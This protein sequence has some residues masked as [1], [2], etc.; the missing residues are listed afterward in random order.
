VQDS[1]NSNVSINIDNPEPKTEIASIYGE[2]PRPLEGKVTVVGEDVVG[3]TWSRNGKDKDGKPS[4]VRVVF[5][6]NMH[7]VTK[8]IGKERFSPIW[9][10]HIQSADIQGMIA[11]KYGKYYKKYN[12]KVVVKVYVHTGWNG[13]GISPSA[14]GSANPQANVGAMAGG[15]LSAGGGENM[16]F[17]D[18]V[19]YA[20]K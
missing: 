19:Y 3:Q 8:A 2:L 9:P 10:H 20:V 18:I 17:A 4:Y 7:P 11:A 16:E 6:N 12:G 14:A 15:F 1:G 5:W 13:W